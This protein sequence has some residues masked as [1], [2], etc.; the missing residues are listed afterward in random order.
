MNKNQD[1]HFIDGERIYLREVRESDVN[2]HYYRWMNDNET[3][4]YL[5]S[6]FFPNSLS[7]ILGF[8]RSFD[9]N[10]NNVF[11]AVIDKKNGQHI[12]NIK[13]GPIQWIHRTAE[14][15][16]LLGEK[17]Y[18]GK[19]FATEALKLLSNYAFNKLNL[20][21]LT[22]GCY[23]LNKGSEALFLKAGF[24]V[25]GVRPQQFFFNGQYVDYVLLGL[26]N[27]KSHF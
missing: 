3:T 9:G 15:G 6:R 7:A 8:V 16:I 19:G 10:V 11:L 4:Q 21:K 2:E 20:R 27:E 17:E 14:V 13:L 18:W 12:G 5:E 23:N 1:A 24:A 25:E 26:I 22:A